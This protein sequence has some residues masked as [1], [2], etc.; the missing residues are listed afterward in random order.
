[1]RNTVISCII[2]AI[3]SLAIGYILHL[4]ANK[5][6]KLDLYVAYDNDYISKPKFPNSNI[7]LKVKNI[8]KEKLGILTISLVNFSSKHY[9]KQDL[10]IDVKP[11]KSDQIDVLTYSAKGQ[12]N[13]YDIV[14]D[15]APQKD[16]ISE[17]GI[18][19]FNLLGV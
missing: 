13:K 6:N 8:D 9:E 7:E 11:D 4:Q 3:L 19:K 14:K 1:M 5:I 10:S 16:I 12:N 15:N 18:Y 17:D 2:T